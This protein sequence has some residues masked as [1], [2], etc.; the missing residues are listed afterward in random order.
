MKTRIPL[1]VL[2]LLAGCDTSSDKTPSQTQGELAASQQKFTLERQRI[3]KEQRAREDRIAGQRSFISASFVS[4]DSNRIEV[5]LRN[6]TDKSIDNQSGSLEVFSA[7]GK[8]ITGI[9][10]TNWVPGDIYLPVGASTR[11][12]KSLELE[13]TEQRNKIV[14]EAQD[15]QYQFTIH[16]IQFI[17]EDEINFLGNTVAAD[18]NDIIEAAS[19]S[20]LEPDNPNRASPEACA[21]NQ[22][23]I[24]TEERSYPGSQCS[25]MERNIDSERFKQEFIRLCQIETRA[26]SA[27]ASVARVQLSSCM[28]SPGG[29]GIVYR[30]RICCDVL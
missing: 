5:L 25:H 26:E 7:E 6:N 3:E 14:R 4:V 27:P 29:Q 10:L 28:K 17:D 1:L 19:I 16:K 2:I 8:Y 9:G 30:K 20:N 22:F 18:E 11:A 23:S 24:E 13:T 12:I 15:Y 21:E